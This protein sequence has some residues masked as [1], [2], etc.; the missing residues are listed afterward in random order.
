MDDIIL[1][2]LSNHYLLVILLE[3]LKTFWNVPEQ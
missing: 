3:F 1:N 2:G